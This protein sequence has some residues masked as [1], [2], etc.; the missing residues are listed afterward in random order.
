[1]EPL[2][3]VE[4]RDSNAVVAYRADDVVHGY[5]AFGYL[6]LFSIATVQMSYTRHLA[7]VFSI[8]TLPHQMRISLRIV[9]SIA[10]MSI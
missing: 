1:M 5:V 4:G 2:S 3:E 8:A 6:I 10:F 7:L 9:E